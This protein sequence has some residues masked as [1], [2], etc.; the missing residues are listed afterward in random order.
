MPFYTVYGDF[1]DI[2]VDKD[3]GKLIFER[4]G[5]NDGLIL[6]LGEEGIE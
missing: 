1:T 2:E 3:E 4:K 5:M 6:E